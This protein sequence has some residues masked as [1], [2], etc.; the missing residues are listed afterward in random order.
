MSIT[1][2]FKDLE[3]NK[4]SFWEPFENDNHFRS[5]YDG[6]ELFVIFK[7]SMAP[8]GCKNFKKGDII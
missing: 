4:F 7:K 6:K 5:R 8:F 3:T 2:E 1:V